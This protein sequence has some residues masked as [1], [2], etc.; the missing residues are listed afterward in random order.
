MS[1][2][3]DKTSA[4]ALLLIGIAILDKEEA[5]QAL[6]AELMQNPIAG[7][8]KLKVVLNRKLNKIEEEEK[9]EADKEAKH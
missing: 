8:A 5:Q 2:E 4:K 3:E 9:K 6:F 7:V 1:D